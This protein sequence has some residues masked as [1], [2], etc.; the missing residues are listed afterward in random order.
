TWLIFDASIEWC[1]QVAWDLGVASTEPGRP[2][3]RGTGGD[4]H[5]LSRPGICVPSAGTRRCHA[6]PRGR[7]LARMKALNLR[8]SSSLDDGRTRPPIREISGVADVSA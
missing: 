3:A 4:R 7:T 5:G 1:H 8:F 6:G 2:A